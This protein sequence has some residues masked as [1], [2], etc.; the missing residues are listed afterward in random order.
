MTT[1]KLDLNPSP[2]TLRLFGL[3]GLVVFPAVAALAYWQK[4]IFSPLSEGTGHT[5][6]YVLLVLAVYCGSCAAAAPK[7]LR[8]LYVLMSV[9]FFPIGVVVSHVVMAIVFYLV[10]TPV[11]IV[12]KIIGRDAMTRKFDPSATTYWVQREPPADVKRYFRQF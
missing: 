6:G 7:L 4:L 11:G 3:T 8:P 10:L 2:R 9:V 12:F 5:T 1:A